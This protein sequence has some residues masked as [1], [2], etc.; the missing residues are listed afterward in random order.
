MSQKS[1]KARRRISGSQ[2]P[3]ETQPRTSRRGF[4]CRIPLLWK[5]ATGALTVILAAIS[6]L[7]SLAV[8]VGAADDPRRTL[9]YS[10]VVTNDGLVPIFIVSAMCVLE[11]A[12]LPRGGII[13]ESGAVFTEFGTLWP[14]QRRTIPCHRFVRG[15]LI[16]AKLRIVVRSR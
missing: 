8:D 10:F 1:N 5:I 14:R 11:E 6:Y 7:P 2:G 13:M 16:R 9:S 15:D 12:L 3:P 4:W